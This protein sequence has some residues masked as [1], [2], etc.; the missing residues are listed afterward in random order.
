MERIFL[1]CTLIIIGFSVD[2]QDIRT[3]RIKKIPVKHEAYFPYF[4]ERSY[5]IYLSERNQEVV[6]LYNTRLRRETPASELR[7]P[8]SANESS[9]QENIRV[10]VAGKTIELMKPGADWLI[11]A[12]AGDHFYIWVSISPN[13]ERLLFTASGKGSYI[14]D[15]D[16]RILSE[17]GYLNAPTW[18]NNDW[19]LGM[20]DQDNGHQ[21]ESSDIISI[22]VPTGIRKNLTGGSDEIALHP[23]SSIA[24][25][26]IV[27]HNLKG[28]AFTMRIKIRD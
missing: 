13:G 2:A 11:L 4:G 28:E 16:G 6:S 27:F 19:V 17:L 10:R 21:I 5:E 3:K 1:L 7:D 9:Q 25:D 24:A 22:H 8:N 15:L 23:K 14:S 12:P 26:R 18:M 20:N